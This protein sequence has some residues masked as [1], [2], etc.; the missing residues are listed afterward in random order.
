MEFYNIANK[1]LRKVEYV[2]PEIVN[3]NKLKSYIND[4]IYNKKS[5]LIY[6]D[7]DPDGM[8]SALTW[9]Y[10]FNALGHMDYKVFKY[11]KRMHTVDPFA[12]THAIEFGYD[13]MIISDA[14]SS[15][16]EM[17]NRLTKFGVKVILVD[18]HETKYRY[19]DYPKDNFV[20]VNTT[21][22]NKENVEILE[23]RQEELILSCGA[24]V[25][26]LAHKILNDYKIPCD[27]LSVL[28]I[29]SMYADCV[30]M[31]SELARGIYF[32]AIETDSKNMPPEVECFINSYTKV[33]RRFVEFHM[34]PKLNA[35]FRSENFRYLNDTFMCSHKST[36]GE[37]IVAIEALTDLHRESV[38]LVTKA[39][40][41]IYH[42]VRDNF[43][44]GNL[45]TVN[46]HIDVRETKLY[47]FTGLI[48]NKLAE[49]YKKSA[50]VYCGLNG[51]V[52]GSFRDLYSRKYLNIF[53]SF[54]DAQGHQAAFGI[55]LN[56]LEMQDFLDCIDLVDRKFAIKG[57]PNEPI[58]EK[59]WG[60]EIPDDKLLRDM[61]IYNEFAG[62][63]LPLALLEVYKNDS[64]TER[65]NAYGGY[66]YRWGH[67]NIQSR[68]RVLNGTRMLIRP[69]VGKSLR[70]YIV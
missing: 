18:H 31:S 47:N 66:V 70:L 1:Y 10:L 68:R 64:M 17:I 57:T 28:A 8:F 19:S 48:A 41:I 29:A 54:C 60:V 27:Y 24:L 65:K 3:Y 45:N 44:I 36:R 38:D 26:V 15:D 39:T 2:S 67:L 30:D 9:K 43:V 35:S 33:S 61:S 34:T 42:E 56:V 46:E 22:E 55:K 21:I 69:T 5:V 62:V 63:S 12:V 51:K 40:D 23:G 4:I 20:I 52:K 11:R 32:L 7:Y 50:V 37:L 14:G 25:F 49:R 13:Y 16:M 6:G 53:Q 58:L 59:G